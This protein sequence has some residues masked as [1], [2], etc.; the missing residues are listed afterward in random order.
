MRRSRER[1]RNGVACLRRIEITETRRV[2]LA[3]FLGLPVTATPEEI[4]KAIEE[5]PLAV[6]RNK[7]A[8]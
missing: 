5:K 1:K 6:A 2:E 7:T 4:A 8:D 3:K